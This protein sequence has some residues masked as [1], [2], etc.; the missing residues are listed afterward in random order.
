MSW[1]NLLAPAFIL[2]ALFLW[3]VSLLVDKPQQPLLPPAP[4]ARRDHYDA[5]RHS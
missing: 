1:F 4:E 3:L 5:R 2:A